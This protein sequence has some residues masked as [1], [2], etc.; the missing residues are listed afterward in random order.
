MTLD[1]TEIRRLFV[2]DE[3]WNRTSPSWKAL[4]PRRNFD[5]VDPSDETTEAFHAR[6]GATGF[7]MPYLVIDQWLYPHYYNRNTVNNYGWLDYARVSWSETLLPVD[8]LLSLCVIEQYREWVDGRA[9]LRA[10]DEFACIPQDFEHWKQLR[11]WRVPPVV[12]DVSSLSGAPP[13]AEL[14]GTLQL[15]EGH[16]RLGYLL[17]AERSGVLT[18]RHH[19]VFMLRQNR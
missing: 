18:V 19:R 4:K 9:Q 11:T 3:E 17:A 14:A 6:V 16:T 1:E 13:Y 5:Q 8:E 7:N 10:F 15:V 12:L 2:T